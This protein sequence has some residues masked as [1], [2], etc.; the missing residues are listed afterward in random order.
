MNRKGDQCHLR[1][2]NSRRD[3][4][5]DADLPKTN[6]CSSAS[7][8]PLIQHK[9]MGRRSKSALESIHTNSRFLLC[10][11]KVLKQ[12]LV[13]VP[14]FALASCRSGH[15]LMSQ[16]PFQMTCTAQAEESAQHLITLTASPELPQA[17]LQVD[18]EPSRSLN[19][20]SVSPIEIQIEMSQDYEQSFVDLIVINRQTREIRS[21]SENALNGDILS[22]EPISG[23]TF[24]SL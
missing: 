11:H 20:L 10:S 21:I 16:K 3:P 23:C 6:F 9:E 13:V 24:K 7:L 17:T 1:P 14:V 15:D 19:V 22:N 2:Q 4:R 12:L 8:M 5:R 18:D